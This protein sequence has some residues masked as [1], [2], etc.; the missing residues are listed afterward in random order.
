MSVSPEFKEFLI[1]QMAGFGAVTIRSMFGGAGVYHNSLMF[2]LIDDDMLYLKADEST[3]SAFEAEGLTQFVYLAK[4]GTKMEM[5]YWHIP[6]RCLDEPDEMAKWCR[7][8]YDVA[9][10]AAT[11]K[12]KK[13]S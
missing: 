9:L 13:K 5:G 1:E 11:K 8:A 10:K 2:A 4:G 7:E 3:K 12:P 6:P